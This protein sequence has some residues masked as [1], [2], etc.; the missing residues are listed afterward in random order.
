MD[1]GKWTVAEAKAKFSEVIDS[2]QNKGPQTITRN[3]RTAVVVVSAKEWD[4]KPIA[5]EIWP[6]SSPNPLCAGPTST[7]GV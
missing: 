6:R 2:A 3:G 1:G 7:S 5:L 4:A